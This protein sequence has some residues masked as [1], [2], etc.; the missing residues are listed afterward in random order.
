MNLES[1][2]KIS[3]LVPFIQRFLTQ[4]KLSLIFTKTLLLPN[5]TANFLNNLHDA[6]KNADGK[7]QSLIPANICWS[8][9]RRR[10]QYVFSVTIF[11]LSRHLERQKIVTL[12]TSSRRLEDISWRYL[13]DMSWRCLQN[14]LETNKV[15]SGVICI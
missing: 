10:L 6:Y 4:S 13:E 3:L 5:K 15:F 8:S 11:C 2:G 9:R 7:S 14:V 1:E 12:K